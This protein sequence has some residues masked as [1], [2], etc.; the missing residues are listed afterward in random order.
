MY[1]K[2]IKIKN[3][4]NL[5]DL[6][7]NFSVKINCFT[8]NN[9]MGKTNLLDA[10]YF[11]SNTR[12]YFNHIDQQNIKYGEKHFF[13]EGIFEKNNDT[14][15]VTSS[16]SAEKGKTFKL[17]NKKQKKLSAHYGLFPV[18]I[19]TPYDINL[20]TDGSELRRSFVDSIISLYDKEY[21]QLLINYKK[22][23]S[24][25]NSLLK[26]FSEKKIFDKNYLEIFDKKI[27]DISPIIHQKRKNFITNLVPLFNTYY[28]KISGNNEEVGL[29]YNSELNS[30]KIED[31]LENNQTKD[32]ILNRTTGGIHKDDLLF[33]INDYP[34]KKH[35]SQGQQK[36]YLTAL[37][38]AQSDFLK[39]YTG[40]RPIMLLDDI[41]DK[42]DTQRVQNIVKLVSNEHFGQIFITHTD[43]NKLEQILKPVN[44]DFLVFD[45]NKGEASNK[46]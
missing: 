2:K 33:T 25:R 31:I 43:K 24:Q 6:E 34:L 5:S 40:I 20:I 19:I 14:N 18:I 46:K 16:F 23:L 7:L 36:T 13:I 28:K 10:I 11:L 21:L 44:N 8:G 1:L 37:K 22:I 41:F 26:K 30:K 27:I 45:I 15:T 35:G 17:N 32:R 3:Y 39:K 38:F 12:S 4:K 29:K 42:L 9:G